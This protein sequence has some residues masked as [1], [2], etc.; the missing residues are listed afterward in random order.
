MHYRLLIAIALFLSAFMMSASDAAFVTSKK[1]ANFNRLNFNWE[2]QV[3]YD[4]QQDGNLVTIKFKR[5]HPITKAH[6]DS[7]LNSD[8]VVV[9]SMN[10]G[11]DYLEL[12]FELKKPGTA[13]TL[14]QGGQVTLDFVFEKQ[15]NPA[16]KIEAK[17]KD[18]PQPKEDPKKKE[19][20]PKDAPKAAKADKPKDD[21]NA[22]KV[23]KPKAAPVDDKTTSAPPKD[24]SLAS[25]GDTAKQDVPEQPTSVDIKIEE[26]VEGLRLIFDFP[27]PTKAGAF[28]EGDDLWLFFD[29]PTQFSWDDD[30]LKSSQLI[31][32]LVTFKSNN[33][34]AIKIDMDVEPD[35]SSFYARGNQWVLETTDMQG[36]APAPLTAR[37]ENGAISLS[38]QNLGEPIYAQM[39]ISGVPRYFIPVSSGAPRIERTYSYLDFNMP[40]TYLGVVIDPLSQGMHV[41]K[42]EQTIKISK[43]GG[44]ALSDPLD[45]ISNRVRYML[46]SLFNFKD[47][48]SDAQDTAENKRNY[49]MEIIEAPKGS[50]TPKR[51][52]L[53]RHYILTRRFLEARGLLA[54][55]L[56]YDPGL[57]KSPYYHS[58]MGLAA[59]ESQHYEEALHHFQGPVLAGDPEM[60]VWAE[61]CKCKYRPLEVNYD[62][63]ATGA[64]FFNKYPPFIKNGVLL[65]AADAAITQSKDA[66]IFLSILDKDNLT[67]IQ[68]DHLNFLLAYY[69]TQGEKQGE[70]MSLLE[71]YS[72]TMSGEFRMKSGLLLTQIKADEKLISIDDEIKALEKIRYSWSG[73]YTEYQLWTRLADLYFGTKNYERTLKFLRKSIRNYPK[74]AT[75]DGLQAKGEGYLNDALSDN[76]ADLLTLVGLVQEYEIFVPIDGRRLKVN[77]QLIDILVK[78]DLLDQAMDLL[79]QLLKDQS[80]PEDKKMLLRTRYALLA[81]LNDDPDKALSVLNFKPDENMEDE[82]GSQRKFLAAQA[83]LMQDKP[84][85]T[86]GILKNENGPAALEMMTQSYMD[87]KDWAG[88]ITYINSYIDAQKTAG[89]PIEPISILHLATAYELLKKDD[90]LKKLRKDYLS[91]MLGSPYKEAFEIITTEDPLDFS[92]AGLKDELSKSKELTGYLEAYRDKIKQ[93]GLSAVN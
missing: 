75:M 4:M 57:D 15:E 88:L 70:A 90:D 3:K 79:K 34:S 12:I 78:A 56:S 35:K 23:D 48:T 81:L 45:I 38:D 36:I 50:R 73:D 77:E 64:R 16:A 67:D 76:N 83:Y 13:L 85:I 32:G 69:D 43:D 39:P 22:A 6:L 86:R 63:L 8:L 58:L 40:P 93:H 26:P 55:S 72:Q 62:L 2:S 46:P 10:T 7:Q 29:L 33:L 71:N 61:L 89:A 51:M 65:L 18:N 53:V 80:I 74:F 14:N 21:P 27:Q 20:K 84:E 49:Q 11:K 47:W 54:V 9:R 25:S 92:S 87:Q 59:F 37:T 5:F 24:E 31:T 66:S 30:K 44:L 17:Q 60:D 19:D 91:L 28:L 41:D 42:T 68:K 82:M 52:E 1:K